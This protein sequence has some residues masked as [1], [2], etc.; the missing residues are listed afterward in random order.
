M[1]E[2]KEVINLVFCHNVTQ[3]QIY[4][5]TCYVLNTGFQRMLVIK[6]YFIRQTSIGNNNQYINI[7]QQWQIRIK[8]AWLYTLPCY[9]IFITIIALHFIRIIV[10]YKWQVEVISLGITK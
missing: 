1:C 6:F 5:F 4:I 3:I 10:K 2:K 7:R 9:T 8:C